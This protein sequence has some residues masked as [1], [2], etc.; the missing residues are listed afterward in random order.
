MTKKEF[1]KKLLFMTAT[2]IYQEVLS[3][4]YLKHF[5]RY[6][7]NK[8]ESIEYAK[9]ITKYLIE[10][11]LKWTDD[12]IKEKLNNLTFKDNNLIGMLQI[13]FNNS[14]F[15]AF[16][17]A[18]PDKFK[19]WEFQKVPRNFWDLK[20]AKE[21]VKWLI[22]DK[23]KW[24]DNEIKEKLSLQI[25]KDNNLYG[26]LSNIFNN[27]IF[28]A[29]NNAYPN[30]F[31][32]WEFHKA[33][34][35]FWDLKMAK[36][37]VKWLIED[38]LKWTDNEIKEKWSLQIFKDN[39][40]YGMINNIFNG[41]AF[42]ALNNTYPNKFKPWE[43]NSTP[44]NFWD[45]KT[46]KE[47]VKWLIEDK[48]KWTDNEIKEKLCFQIFKDNNL[49][50]MM[51]ILFNNSPFQAFNNA[52]PDK[53]KPWEF[54]K[55]PRNFWDLKTAKEVVKWLIEDKLKWTDNEIKE[56]LNTYIF[57]DNNLIG[58]INSIFNG[59]AFNA[60]NNAYPNKFKQNEMK[61]FHYY[62]KEG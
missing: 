50:G 26:L 1:R 55:V 62:K 43:F 57:Q 21:V 8:P 46:A 32:P 27:S 10:K 12:E 45:L 42:N 33:P 48:L 47:V 2:D 53:F 20:T 38:K 51:K 34:R 3:G 29:F 61:N 4:R 60:L 39:N 7:W 13:L 6:F 19:P 58:M 31:K 49:Y 35:N 56:K 37:A 17:N 18:Y 30:K 41:S 5:P 59:S 54:Q 22:E 25:F 23:L 24:T 14:P 16:N 52:Y 11:K 9:D 36:E 28:Q 15:Q 44:N 40:L